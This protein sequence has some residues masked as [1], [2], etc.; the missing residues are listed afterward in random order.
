MNR[1]MNP[2]IGLRMFE[3]WIPESEYMIFLIIQI[4]TKLSITALSND[5]MRNM[6]FFNYIAMMH[7]IT[8]NISS[9]RKYQDYV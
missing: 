9:N 1:E 7:R 5:T 3:T 2:L 8:S 6:T 4:K